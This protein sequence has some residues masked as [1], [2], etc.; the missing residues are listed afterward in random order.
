MNRL[1]SR[2]RVIPEKPAAPELRR[3]ITAFCITPRFITAFTTGL[4]SSLSWARSIRYTHHRLYSCGWSLT[5]SLFLGFVIIFFLRGRVF[6]PTPTPNMEGQ[7]IPFFFWV[8]TL[9]LSDMGDPSS[10]YAITSIALRVIWPHKPHHCA[11]IGIT[12]LGGGCWNLLHCPIT[13]FEYAL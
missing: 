9:D 6:S 7:G 4:H 11:K 3:T 10:S 8:I 12:S 2:S 1:T 13:F 5:F